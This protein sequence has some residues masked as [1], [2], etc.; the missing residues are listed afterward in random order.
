MG[1]IPCYFEI[2]LCNLLLCCFVIEVQFD[3]LYSCLAD[4]Y[5]YITIANFKISYFCNLVAFRYI[6][7]NISS[8]YMGCIFCYFEILLCNLLL[9]CFIVEVQFNIS[10]FSVF[11]YNCYIDKTINNVESYI[12]T[13]EIISTRNILK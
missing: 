6:L 5:I 4:R 9:C 12:I 11:L 10:C 3:I 2:L 8:I 1:C 7:R 13:F